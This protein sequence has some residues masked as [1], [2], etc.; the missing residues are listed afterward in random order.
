MHLNENS[1]VL[2]NWPILLNYRLVFQTR[3]QETYDRAYSWFFLAVHKFT[4]PWEP[5]DTVL[6]WTN[7]TPTPWNLSTWCFTSSLEEIQQFCH[8]FSALRF[9]KGWKSLSNLWL[10]SLRGRTTTRAYGRRGACSRSSLCAREL[11]QSLLLSKVPRWLWPP[12]P[13]SIPVS[14]HT[15]CTRFRLPASFCTCPNLAVLA[16]DWFL[17]SWNAYPLAAKYSIRCS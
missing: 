6:A 17:R 11:L 10:S 3:M 1:S 4:I 14:V 5:C 2:T 16:P 12:A 8:F 15:F 13:I 7:E 9:S